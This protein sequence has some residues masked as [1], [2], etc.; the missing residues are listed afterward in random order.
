VPVYL[1]SSVDL[2][3]AWASLDAMEAPGFVRRDVQVETEAGPISA[4]IYVA[5]G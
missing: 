2:P 3:G 1:F 5:E 4:Y